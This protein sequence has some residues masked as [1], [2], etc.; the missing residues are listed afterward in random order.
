MLR[1]FKNSRLW[2]G[3]CGIPL[4]FDFWISTVEMKNMFYIKSHLFVSEVSLIGYSI[5]FYFFVYLFER[6]FPLIGLICSLEESFIHEKNC[7]VGL[8]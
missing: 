1:I 4:K 7:L 6:L 8:A 2:R 3:Y 5:I